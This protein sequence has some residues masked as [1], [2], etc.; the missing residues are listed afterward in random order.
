MSTE[1]HDPV[2][3]ETPVTRFA[4]NP[5]LTCHEV[6]R[7]WGSA[8]LQVKTVHNAGIAEFDGRVVMLFRSHLRNG[9]SVL[10]TARSNDGLGGWQ[11]DPEPAM[12]PCAESDRFAEGTEPAELF[13]NETSRDMHNQGWSGCMDSLDDA[14]REGVV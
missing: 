13:E 8:A 12:L 6:N 7:A 3:L 5:V 2:T 9:I 11:V 14:L 10:G 1:P 4:G